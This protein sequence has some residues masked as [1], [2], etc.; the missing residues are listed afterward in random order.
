MK[1]KS[2]AYLAHRMTQAR[3]YTYETTAPA[4]LWGVTRATQKGK[5]VQEFLSVDPLASS[6]PELTPY[7]FASNSP[8]ENID[9]D[10][11]EAFSV[12]GTFSDNTA[13]DMMSDDDIRRVAGNEYQS[14]NRGF[15]WPKGTNFLSNGPMERQ[16]SAVAL[17]DYVIESY[18]P[19]EEITLV[20]H[21]HGGNVS[22]RAARI[23][24]RRLD[25]NEETKDVPIR[26]VT[27]ATPAYNG[28][29]DLENPANAPLDSHLH[30][31]S[32]NDAVQVRMANAVAAPGRRNA[33]RTYDNDI[34][35]N[36]LVEDTDPETGDP[37]HGGVESHSM[38]NRPDL[39]EVPDDN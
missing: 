36:V 38:Q 7:Q 3:A 19:G 29:F 14:V 33:E 12:H 4:G 26:L 8:I 37:L 31:Y 10:G 34:T 23:L 24:R 32:E 2:C 16:G 11:L 20:A 9:L 5:P 28:E 39:L 1:K 25:A 35:V 27:L 13:F 17:A 6:Y 15:N 18:N 30:F 22:I 21:S